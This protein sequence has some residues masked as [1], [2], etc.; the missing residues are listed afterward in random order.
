MTISQTEEWQALARHA[1]EMRD[2]HLRKLFDSDSARGETYTVE[3]ADLFADYSK[4]RIT[5]ETLRLLLALADKAGLRERIDGMF[6]GEKINTTENRAVLHVALRAPRDEQ[7][8][9][10]GQ[11]VVPE[12]HEVLDRMATFSE[13]VRSGG[14]VG[15]TGE[16]IRNGVNIGIGGSDLGPEMAYLALRYYSDR[17]MTFRFVSNVDG[18][19]FVEK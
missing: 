12:V 10:D 3:A 9:V 13:R 2:V 16:R 15:H 17:S 19:D 1:D 8:F 14:G 11:D 7:I 5:D 18:T 4:H 6:A